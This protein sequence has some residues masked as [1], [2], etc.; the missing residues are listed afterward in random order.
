MDEGR[1]SASQRDLITEHYSYAT[2]LAMRQLSRA[3]SHADREEIISCAYLGLVQAVQR[4]PHYC[5]ER[6]FCERQG[7]EQGYF[8]TYI[9]RRINGA[10]LDHMRDQDWVRRS[11]RSL[12]KRHGGPGVSD[13]EIAERSGS[14]VAQ[15]RAARAEVALSPISLDLRTGS[16]E[17]AGWSPSTPERAD[18]LTMDEDDVESLVEL[19]TVLEVFSNCVDQLDPIE[20]AV[21]I[22]RVWMQMDVR[23]VGA[24]LG[25]RPAQVSV[26]YSQVCEQISTEVLAEMMV[27]GFE[28]SGRIADHLQAAVA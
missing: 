14:S 24:E 3:P 21:F 20:Q 16:E 12:L 28:K 5:A 10:V 8:R 26:I 6:G 19:R 18:I 4:W 23:E 22:M 13:E 11:S 9:T 17:D 15:V 27:T 1:L 2:A 25:I 7:I